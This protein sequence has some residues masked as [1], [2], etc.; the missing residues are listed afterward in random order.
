MSDPLVPDINSSVHS[1][2]NNALTGLDVGINGNALNP[3]LNSFNFGSS[4]ASEQQNFGHGSTAN[5]FV[6]FWNNLNQSGNTTWSRTDPAGELRFDAGQGA[7]ANTQGIPADNFSAR[8]TTRSYFEGGLYDFISQADD[9]IRIY[10]DSI[11]ILDKWQDQPYV[12]ND[13]YVLVPKGY[14]NVQVDYFDNK[15]NA[16]NTLRWDSLSQ[17][18]DWN[19]SIDVVGYDGDAVHSTYVNTFQRNGASTIGAPTNNVHPWG[20]GYTQDFAGGTDGVGAIVKSNANDNS[21]W[22]GGDFWNNFLETGGAGGILGYATSDRYNSNGALRQ[23]FQ[24]GSIFKTARD[25]FALYGGIGSYYFQTAGGEEGRLGLPTSGEQGVGN[26]IIIRQNFENGYILWNGTATGYNSDGSLLFPPKLNSSLNYV[27]F[28]GVVM[29]TT[30][31]NLRNTPQLSART[32]L[33]RAYNERLS[34]DGWTTG[35]TVI[36]L[37]LG[38]PDTRWFHV[39]GTSLWVPS[40]YI[41]GNPPSGI[42]YSSTPSSSVPEGLRKAI[43]G[44]E[45]GYN[46][47]AIN[48]DSG[49]LGF[50]Q[51]MPANIPS[52]SRAALGYE[53][54]ASQFLN[55]PDLQMRIINYKLNEYYQTAISVSCGDMDTAVRRVASAWYSGNP[56]LYTS[57]T[58]Q[59]SGG[60]QYP[61]IASYTLQ[62]L[63]RFRQAYTGGLTASDPNNYQGSSPL[64]SNPSNSNNVAYKGVISSPNFTEKNTIDSTWRNSDVSAIFDSAPWFQKGDYIQALE[65]KGFL[66]TLFDNPVISL[67]NANKHL[68]HFLQQGKTPEPIINISFVNDLLQVLPKLQERYSNG[69]DRAKQLIQDFWS[70]A[71][72]ENGS[73]AIGEQWIE[74]EVEKQNDYPN[75]VSAGFDLKNYVDAYKALIEHDEIALKVLDYYC[76]LGN[77]QFNTQAKLTVNSDS[78]FVLETQLYIH[79]DFN[80]DTKVRETLAAGLAR[81]TSEI[82]KG[83]SRYAQSYWPEKLV[84][85]GMANNYTQW[86]TS[87]NSMFKGRLESDGRV[88]WLA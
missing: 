44:Q 46:F 35:E 78:S 13:A 30:G 70:T 53:I 48:P 41:N 4:S 1:L 60:N 36:D 52:W 17:L 33:N 28:S 51:V 72:Q 11:K 50:A 58:P 39:A 2:N 81:N 69:I 54:S 23:D 14:H 64:P 84:N 29:S 47:R 73:I 82:G 12:R 27:D 21:Y 10:I 31:V 38:T 75:L 87:S 86:G 7:P 65:A 6:Q 76:V 34:F 25:V 55:S 88:T 67:P 56:N 9:G 8:W 19:G 71:H 59:Y 24:G 49:A 16:I 57:T 62:V 3:F 42:T 68:R 26:G 66:W 77:F 40:A 5:W 83:I 37:A 80:F 15:F 74:P 43:I 79:D 45:S 22:V 18:T 85:Y 32:N 61:S 63:E 20:D